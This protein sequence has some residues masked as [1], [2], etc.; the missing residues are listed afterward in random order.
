MIAR[1]VSPIMMPFGTLE[2]CLTLWYNLNGDII[3]TLKLIQKELITK[4]EK[5]LW[6]ITGNKGDKWNEVRVTVRSGNPFQVRV[7]FHPRFRIFL[8]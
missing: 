4:V 3:G 8:H 6:Q 2:K 5:Q 7:H 1:F